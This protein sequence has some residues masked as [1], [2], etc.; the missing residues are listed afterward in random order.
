MRIE[1][2]QSGKIEQLNKDTYIAFSNDEQYC[3]KLPKKVKQDISL[4]H[5]GKIGQLIQK[6]FAIS[7]YYCLVNYLNN[8][9]LI[10][11]DREYSGW[12]P[13]IKRELVNLIKKDYH[14]FDMGIIVFDL[15]TKNSKAH[16]IAL[17]SFR[18]EERPNKI[19]SREDIE[20]WL[21]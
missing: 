16:K 4:K 3:I 18:E 20:R 5:R 12:E 19:L 17:K 8:K 21:K 1:I 9:R 7:I 14:N 13:F 11:I 2:D 15:I 10:V 6:I